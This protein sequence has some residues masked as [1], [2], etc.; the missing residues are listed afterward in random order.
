MHDDISPLAEFERRF[1]SNTVDHW[2]HHRPCH[3]FEGLSASALSSPDGQRHIGRT[4]EKAIDL[5]MSYSI[6]PLQVRLAVIKVM[7]ASALQ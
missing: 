4:K 3:P 6:N 5:K 1:D 2:Y 7:S